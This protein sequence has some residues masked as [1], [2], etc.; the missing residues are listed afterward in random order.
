ML[1]LIKDYLVKFAVCLAFWFTVLV[2]SVVAVVNPVAVLL[3]LILLV[4]LV[5]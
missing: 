5:K 1:N 2:L 4:L 3:L